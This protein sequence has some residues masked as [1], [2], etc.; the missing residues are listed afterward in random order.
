MHF[1]TKG[2]LFIFCLLHVIKT[3]YNPLKVAAQPQGLNQ[4]SGIMHDIWFSGG[5][6]NVW[7]V[8]RCWET[9]LCFGVTYRKGWSYFIYLVAQNQMT[10]TA[11]V[12]AIL[13]SR[14]NPLSLHNSVIHPQRWSAVPTTPVLTWSW[15]LASKVF[16]PL[17]TERNARYITV[18]PFHTHR[19]LYSPFQHVSQFVILNLWDCLFHVPCRPTCPSWTGGFRRV[20][21]ANFPMFRA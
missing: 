17:S 21:F 5:R 1:Q 2:Y 11:K 12:F 10:P 4:L 9:S 3:R 13:P 6:E 16:S 7:D 8:G 19:A 15:I 14:K 18:S 20:S